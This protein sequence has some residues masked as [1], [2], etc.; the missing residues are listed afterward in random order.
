MTATA[1][2]RILLCAAL[3]LAAA[4]AFADDDAEQC[5][6]EANDGNIGACQ[7]AVAAHPDDIALRRKLALSLIVAGA[8]E[9]ALEAYRDAARR[10]PDDAEAQYDLAAALG[11]ANRFA[12][13][14][15]PI[16]RA[17]ALVPDEPRYQRLADIV[18]A[19]VGAQDKR[20]RVTLMEAERGDRIAM[21]EIGLF[22]ADG[23]GVTRDDAKALDWLMR[24][25]ARD[26]VGAMDRL[27]EVYAEGKLG[28]KVDA[29]EAESWAAK[30]QAARLATE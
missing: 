12:G 6:R 9:P 29:V 18:Y 10:A 17:L 25:A 15:A 24:A 8:V 11:T 3:A 2:P 4:P 23:M 27:A 5:V 13:A 28:Q 22:Y 16:E 19:H 1:L 14:V 21:Y 20:F 7:R 30:A 26:H